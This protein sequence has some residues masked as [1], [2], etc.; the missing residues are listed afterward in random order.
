MSTAQP[1]DKSLFFGFR[2]PPAQ[3]QVAMITVAGLLGWSAVY[4]ERYNLLPLL[5]MMALFVGGIWAKRAW[6]IYLLLGTLIYLKY[7]AMVP[8]FNFRVRGL[9]NSDPVTAL[10]L[11]IFAAA[12]F[13][14]LQ[15]AK[16]LDAFYPNTKLGEKPPP[17]TKF[18][19]PSLLGGRW[20]AIPL[21]VFLSLVLLRICSS[22]SSLPNVPGIRPQA[23]RLIF[24]TLFLFFAWFVCRAL[25]GILNRWR[26]KPSQAD[27]YCRSLV[28]KEFWKDSYSIE[29]RYV[30]L[31]AKQQTKSNR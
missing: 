4:F 16:F 25:L 19:F 13:R 1:G 23:A 29:K 28:A 24:L 15:T 22:G 9:R 31:Q 6:A 8:E 26:M 11:M 12:C 17:E 3:A 14:F 30:K 2:I 10:V 18:E 5:M 21:S 27:V 7:F 20:W